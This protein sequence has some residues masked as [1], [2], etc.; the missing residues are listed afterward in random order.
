MTNLIEKHFSCGGGEE[1]KRRKRRNDYE[2]ARRNEANWKARS[3]YEN[4]G[5]KVSVGCT[6][7]KLRGEG[8]NL[9]RSFAEGELAC[10]TTEV[11]GHSSYGPSQR[12]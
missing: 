12:R 5:K 1:L 4:R 9:E 7:D 11:A 2:T 8:K 10:F 3:V 6:F